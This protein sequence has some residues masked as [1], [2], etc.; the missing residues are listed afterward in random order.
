MSGARKRRGTTLLEL[1]LVI[2]ILAMVALPFAA[3]V[4]QN[5]KNT[6]SASTQLKEQMVLEQVMQDMEKHLRSAISM[7][8]TTPC[9][10]TFPTGGISFTSRDPQALIEYTY[11]LTGGLLTKN[12]MTFPDGLEAGLI[13]SLTFPPPRAPLAPC[14]I[15]VRLQAGTTELQKTIYLRDYY[16]Y[17]GFTI[18]NGGGI[19]VVG[20]DLR[21][22]NINDENRVAFGD[23]SWTDYVVHVRATLTSGNGYGIYYRCDGVLGNQNPGVSGYCFQFDPGAGNTLTVRKVINGAEQAAFQSV[24]M[25]ANVVASLYGPHDIDV[26]VKGDHHVISVDGVILLDFHDIA[27]PSGMAGLR[28]W[29]GCVPSFSAVSVTPNP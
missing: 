21:F 24:A 1:S 6:V 2:A 28:G 7:N 19:A 10:I 14:Y 17:Y 29:S 23:L 4:S 15:T 8:G 26:A 25:P 13:T 27:Y 18:L 5:L 9:P 16:Y 20:S 11:M 12:G 22:T 3:F